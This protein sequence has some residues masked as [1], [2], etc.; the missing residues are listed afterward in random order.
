MRRLDKQQRGFFTI[1]EWGE[2]ELQDRLSEFSRLYAAQTR[3]AVGR[4]PDAVQVRH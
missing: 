3:G 1:S 2:A 4:D